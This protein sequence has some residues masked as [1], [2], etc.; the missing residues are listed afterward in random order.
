ME[1]VKNWSSDRERM[2]IFR[3]RDQ[4]KGRKAKQ[5]LLE[6]VLNFTKVAVGALGHQNTE[7]SFH[8]GR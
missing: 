2:D 5:L 3:V 7:Q 1:S 8:K 6:T 4:L